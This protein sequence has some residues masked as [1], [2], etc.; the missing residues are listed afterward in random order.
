M[1]PPLILYAIPPRE[2]HMRPALQISAHLIAR[3]LDVTMLG[4][5][6][7]SPAITA[8]GAH[9]SH[10]IGLWDAMGDYAKWGDIIAAKTPEERLR[11]SL[12]D[13]FVRLLPSALESIRI[14][15]ANIRT[16]LGGGDALRG[17]TVVVLSDTCLSGTLPL[18]LGADLPQGYEGVT[19]KTVGI[20]L[21]P[22]FWAAPER[23]PWGSGMPYDVSKEGIAR[24]LKAH[25]SKW[26]EIAEER[27][28]WVLGAMNC[29]KSVDELYGE[30]DK[31]QMGFKRPFWDASTV[32][33]DVVFQMGLPSFEFPVPNEPAH[34]RFAGSLPPKPIPLDLQYPDWYPEVLENSSS[35]GD[36]PGRKRIVFVAQGTEVLDHRDLL[37]PC[38]KGLAGREDVLVIAVLC[39]KG[40]TL[41]KHL[42]LFEGGVLPSNARVIDYF[43]YDAILPHA[44]V[45]ASNSGYGGLTH[46][47][48]QAVPVVQA[49]DVFDKPDIGRR[50][51]YSGLG[52][53]L[54][55][56]PPTSEA[57]AAA[58]D[59][60]LAQDKYK[61]RALSLQAEARE[62]NPL[63][64]IEDGIRALS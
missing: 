53:F 37:V 14:A 50:V 46:A 26:D 30:Y 40:A 16:R 27:A 8:I 44:D 58:V 12:S 42:S 56:S 55:K 34:L 1:A 5:D 48:A 22:R 57:V 11:I 18:K 63:Q 47:V 32:C 25:A 24:T 4:D 19:I 39:Q 35:S 49:G 17:R 9:P 62:Y 15:L 31:S 28:R 41:D 51:E 36:R 6:K 52:V 61:I 38:L 45:F 59:G 2:G 33:H 23:P 54:P 13:G 60:V 43:P 29:S 3:G 21:V 10:I 7:W 64:I 20:G